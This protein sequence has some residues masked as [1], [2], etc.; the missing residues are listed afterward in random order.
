MTAA[1]IAPGEGAELT[2]GGRPHA[3]ATFET[4]TCKADVKGFTVF[5]AGVRLAKKRKDKQLCA[6]I[7]GAPVE[8]L[9]EAARAVRQGKRAP[10]EL[11]F[12]PKRQPPGE[13]CLVAPCRRDLLLS[14]ARA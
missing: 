10:V 7:A 12:A 1:A 2:S 6:G 8:E 11:I 13:A 5:A 4:Q 3:C 14:K 9:G